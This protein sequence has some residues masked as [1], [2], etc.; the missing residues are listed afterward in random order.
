MKLTRDKVGF[1][2]LVLVL[3]S[4]MK[5]LVIGSGGREHALV[6]KL[7]Q[8]A[9]VQKVW[10]APGNAG[11]ALHA[12]C[13]PLDLK[14]VPA[15]ADLAESLGADLTV[16]GPELPLALGI[17]NEFAR[18]GLA[19]LG[20]AREAAQLEGSKIFAKQFMERHDIPT[21]SVYGIC[22]SAVDARRVLQKA[23]WPV[24]IKADGLCAGK[25][26]LVTSS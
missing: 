13:L 10:C 26:V 4:I 19:I 12:E 7:R 22:D 17:V 14:D 24:V 5:I 8:G 15:A 6:W 23:E 9:S 25:G 16:V 2:F 20:P 11:I 21:A 1:M 3:G 18:R